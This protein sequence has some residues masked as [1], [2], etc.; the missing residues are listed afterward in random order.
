MA[1]R[2]N[3]TGLNKTL[4]TLGKTGKIRDDHA[5]GI[6][7][8]RALAAAVDADPCGKCGAGQNAALWREYRAAVNDLLAALGAGDE[9]DDD[10]KRFLVTVQ[11]PRRAEVGDPP[12][13]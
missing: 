3:L 12:Q 11:T 9:L 5:A 6:A 1:R 4:R 13:S 10:T 8:A 2:P 7:L